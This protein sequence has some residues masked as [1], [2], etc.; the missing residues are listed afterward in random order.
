MILERA[1]TTAVDYMNA[2]GVTALMA[3]ARSHHV[4]I[5]RL[6]AERGANVSSTTNQQP[7][8]TPLRLALVA[9]HPDEPP[10]HPDP[11]GARQ[12]ATVRALL[13]LGAGTLPPRPLPPSDL[14]ALAQPFF[15]KTQ[16]S[17]PP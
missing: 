9:T 1:P 2:N 5:L 17:R 4:G 13:R 11:G 15:K 3:A 10:R 16:L 6:L 8:N 7:R 14:A 12:L